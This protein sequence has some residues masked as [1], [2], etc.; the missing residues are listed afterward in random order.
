MAVICRSARTR[1][2]T[3]SISPTIAG[4]ASIVTAPT[5]GLVRHQTEVAHA[6]SGRAA[7]A[8]GNRRPLLLFSPTD[9]A[10]AEARRRAYRD[11]LA[12]P[13]ADA[14]CLARAGPQWR[15]GRYVTSGEPW[16]KSRKIFSLSTSL[17]S[18][19]EAMRG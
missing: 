2:R 7:L 4:F 1:L 3:K 6:R 14:S 10:T 19:S 8:S 12:S 16:G 18:L 17:G 15:V 9:A 11:Q 13:D 5:S